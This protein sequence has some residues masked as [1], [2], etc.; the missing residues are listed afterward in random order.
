[1]KI[2]ERVNVCSLSQSVQLILM[3][4]YV[5]CTLRIGITHVYSYSKNNTVSN[6]IGRRRNERNAVRE[7]QVENMNEVTYTE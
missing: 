6:E 4:K 2:V 5:E 3:P 1:M 7:S